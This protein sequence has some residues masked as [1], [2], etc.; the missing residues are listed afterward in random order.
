[1]PLPVGD[2]PGPDGQGGPPGQRCG[3]V[4]GRHPPAP[5]WLPGH[6]VQPGS[7]VQDRGGQLAGCWRV[8]GVRDGLATLTDPAGT[9]CQHPVDRLVV[10]REFGQPVYPRMRSLGAVSR[11]GPDRPWHAVIN[12]ENYH[13]LQA[14][15]YAVAGQADILYLDPP[16]NSGARDWA[17]NNR[18]AGPGDADGHSRWL[19]FMEQRLLASRHLLKDDAVLV[20]TI[21]EHEVTRL[22]VLLGQVFP[23]ADITLVTIVTNPKGVT[24]PGLRRFSR[25]GEYA[26]FCFFGGAGLAAWPDDMLTTGADR[27]ANGAASAAGAAGDPGAASAPPARPRWKGLLRSG[28]GARREDRKDMFYP[29]LV[30]PARSAVLAAGDPLPYPEPPDFDTPVGGLTPVWPVRR[31]GSLGRWSVGQATLQALID[32]GYVALGSYDAARRSYGLTYLSRE[33]Q[34]Q[35]AAGVLEVL[36]FDKARNVVDV[37]YAPASSAGRRVKTVWHRTAHDAGVG[38]TDVISGLLGGRPFTFPKSVYA[39]RDTL[40]MLSA[41]KKDALIIDYFAGSGTTA[42]AAMMLNAEDGGT[43]RTIL[44]TNNEVEAAERARLR[45]AGVLPGAPGWEAAGVFTGQPGHGSKP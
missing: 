20:V 7:Q 15:R 16:Y 1:M 28:D 22:G 24:R 25:V 8:R 36:S 27:L 9:E 38:G 19:S 12:A 3:L 41:D 21:D 39:V 33:P 42:H 23:D 37:A 18:Y 29:V 31:D 35:I 45:A 34:E 43:R 40:G 44:I 10:V 32:T 30:D 13:A 11:G 4:F 17:Y 5:A 6:P 2:R 26:Y 14:L